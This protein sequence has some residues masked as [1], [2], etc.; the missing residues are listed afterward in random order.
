MHRWRFHVAFCCRQ[1]DKRTGNP[2]VWIY[3]DKMTSVP[4]GEATVTF[5]DPATAKAAIE[6]FD[7]RF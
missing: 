2:K 1:T 4:K 6:W 7:G 3:K 5:E